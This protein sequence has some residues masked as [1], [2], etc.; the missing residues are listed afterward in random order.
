M[1]TRKIILTALILSATINVM[2]ALKFAKVFYKKSEVNISKSRLISIFENLNIDSTDI[3][4]FGDSQ[5][6]F[7]PA[8]EITKNVNI[9]NRGIG[10]DKASQAIHRVSEIALK[11]PRRIYIELGI[12][13]L[14]DGDSNQEVVN[15]II[16]IVDT[17]R[18]YSKSTDISVVSI[19]PINENKNT[20]KRAS[21]RSIEITNTKLE[22]ICRSRGVQF[23]DLH[24]QYM[25]NGKLN[26]EYDSGDGLHLNAKAYFV[27]AELIAK[28]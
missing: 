4:L 16:R 6:Q 7:F 21:N 10:G 3:V 27:W 15:N 25:L 13:D 1:L 8:S 19:F 23:I 12:N 26:P 20:S 24:H 5:T 18:R 28:E 2:F 22:T 17:I 11:K 14:R 9:K